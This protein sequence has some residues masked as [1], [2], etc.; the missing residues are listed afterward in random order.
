MKF[1]QN[2]VTVK[3]I[4][5]KVAELKKMLWLKLYSIAFD[6]IFANIH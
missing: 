1:V 6:F 4:P 2:A 3:F 5:L